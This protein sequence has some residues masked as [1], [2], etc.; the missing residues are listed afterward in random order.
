[1]NNFEYLRLQYS[2]LIKK[3]ALRIWQPDKAFIDHFEC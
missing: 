1:M 2:T 3:L